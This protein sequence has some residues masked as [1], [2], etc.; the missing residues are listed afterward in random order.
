M[1]SYGGAL[2]LVDA[3]QA[4]RDECAAGEVSDKRLCC[5]KQSRGDLIGK[6]RALSS[7]DCEWSGAS[8]VFEDLVCVVECSL[9][10]DGSLSFLH[11]CS[12]KM[13]LHSSKPSDNS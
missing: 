10:Q 6:A 1:S 7:C 5:S 2:A 4:A 8:V 3:K 11:F 13:L 9:H 12:S